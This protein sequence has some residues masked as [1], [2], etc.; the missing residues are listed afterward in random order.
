[1][2]PTLAHHPVLSRTGQ[3]V[4]SETYK[5]QIPKQKQTPV[6]WI[7]IKLAK[8]E[9]YTHRSGLSRAKAAR[10]GGT[11]LCPLLTPTA[12]YYC[13]LATL[14]VVSIAEFTV[15]IVARH[16]EEGVGVTESC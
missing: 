6:W 8:R 4:Q 9:A 15:C 5:S 14:E 3:V 12:S 16:I 1:M 11:D 13:Y 7:Q 2:V 10:M